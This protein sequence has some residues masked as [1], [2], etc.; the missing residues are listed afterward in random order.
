MR[1]NDLLVTAALLIA[2]TFG[3]GVQA[4]DTKS[5]SK[6]HPAEVAEIP[7]SALK[8][9]TLTQQAVD[10]LGLVITPVRE[11][12]VARKQIIA[13]EI[14]PAEDAKQLGLPATPQPDFGRTRHWLVA[15]AALKVST[16]SPIDMASF[17]PADGRAALVRVRQQEAAQAAGSSFDKAVVIMARTAT[18]GFRK[19]RGYPVPVPG[20]PD[21]YYV[22]ASD[23]FAPKQPALVQILSN[24]ESRLVVPFGAILYDEHGGAWVYTSPETRVFVRYPVSVDY[25]SG[26][27]AFL[28][29]GPPDGTEVV[30]VGASLLLGT[31]FEI[32][33]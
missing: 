12:S 23:D 8:L 28:T 25:V 21:V 2:G 33:H 11:E 4:A 26:E 5:A 19:L 13:G 17:E 15:S 7:G 30:A 22:V 20:S 1:R 24:V 9:L 10:R 6:E 32:G 14:V 29:E 18:S 31:E 27:T 3:V 16:G